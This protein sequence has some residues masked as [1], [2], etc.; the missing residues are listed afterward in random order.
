MNDSTNEKLEIVECIN[1][2]L[3]GTQ[4]SDQAQ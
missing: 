1:L 2:P 3:L 4:S